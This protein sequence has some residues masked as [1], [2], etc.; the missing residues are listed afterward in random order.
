MALHLVSE[1]GVNFDLPTVASD[2]QSQG[3]VHLS[4]PGDLS[5]SE[6]VPLEQHDLMMSSVSAVCHLVQGAERRQDAAPV[7]L[8]HVSVLDHLIQ[9]NVDSVQVEHDLRVE[10]RVKGTNNRRK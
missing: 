6:G 4:G 2:N 3:A 1:Q 5:V 9:D 8:H 7:G 10:P